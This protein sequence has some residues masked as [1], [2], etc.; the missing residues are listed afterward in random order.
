MTEYQIINAARLAENIKKIIAATQEPATFKQIAE[1]SGLHHCNISTIIRRNEELFNYMGK[2]SGVDGS[3]HKQKNL[4]QAKSD[5]EFKPDVATLG[6][7]TY[8]LQDD[9]RYHENMRI[10]RENRKT[11]TVYVSGS[12][13][14][15]A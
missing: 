7:V 8:R 13:L 6:A 3:K 15:C 14:N 10:L 11:M 5:A 2:V 1:A 12:T 4:Y 9:K